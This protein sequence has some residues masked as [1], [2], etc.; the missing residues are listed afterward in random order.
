MKRLTVADPDFELSGGAGG[1]GFDSLA[2]P[3]AFLPSVIS[4]FS[5]KIRGRWGAG[6]PRPLP[7][8]RH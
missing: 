3:A 5:P 1:G 4:S 6:S 8:I 2:L 7:E